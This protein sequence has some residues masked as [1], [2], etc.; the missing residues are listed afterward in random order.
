MAQT[1]YV[2]YFVDILLSL[3]SNFSHSL[4]ANAR[5]LK[6]EAEVL[7]R[8]PLGDRLALV[9]GARAKMAWTVR[10]QGLARKCSPSAGGRQRLANVLRIARHVSR[11]VQA[12]VRSHHTAERFYHIR[13]NETSL[14]TATPRIGEEKEHLVK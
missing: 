14:R 9:L 8:A 12:A 3:G 13:T 10:G 2:Y 7:D 1:V 4:S 5:C 6:D 11:H